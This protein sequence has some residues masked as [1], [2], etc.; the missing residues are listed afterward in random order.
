MSRAP[1]ALPGLSLHGK[2]MQASDTDHGHVSEIVIIMGSA[3]NQRYSDIYIGVREDFLEKKY[4]SIH[5]LSSYL[6]LD[7]RQGAPKKIKGEEEEERPF[8][9]KALG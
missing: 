6:Y 1:E 2:G 4:F 9:I 7:L 8:Y 3:M 5:F